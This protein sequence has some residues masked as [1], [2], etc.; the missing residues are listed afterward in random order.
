MPHPITL[1]QAPFSGQ[2]DLAASQAAGYDIPIG[3]AQTPNLQDWYKNLGIMQN[4]Y[5]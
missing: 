5:R 4:V 3:G 2:T 1:P